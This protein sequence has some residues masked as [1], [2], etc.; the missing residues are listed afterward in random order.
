MGPLWKDIDTNWQRVETQ[1]RHLQWI[2][3]TALPGEL[4]IIGEKIFSDE[5]S[6]R[7]MVSVFGSYNL[8]YIPIADLK[9]L[10]IFRKCIIFSP[11]PL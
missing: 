6:T 2:L 10:E 8:R 5:S 7:N 9:F 3:D 4:G 11:Q 1:L